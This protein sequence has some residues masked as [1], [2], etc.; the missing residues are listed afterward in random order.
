MHIPHRAADP[1]AVTV[2]APLQD[3]IYP[4]LCCGEAR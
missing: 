4:K 1:I 2:G 3:V